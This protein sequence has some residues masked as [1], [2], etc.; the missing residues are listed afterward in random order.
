MCTKF[1][2][3]SFHLGKTGGGGECWN[4]SLAFVSPLPFV[5]EHR[6]SFSP[7]ALFPNPGNQ[8]NNTVILAV[9]GGILSS[10]KGMEMT[11][12]RH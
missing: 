10:I 1:S 5:Q 4:F 2:T 6:V 12:L 8:P 7:V 9:T 11:N 3:D